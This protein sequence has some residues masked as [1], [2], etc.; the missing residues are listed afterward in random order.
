M[1]A[2]PCVLCHRVVTKYIVLLD[3]AKPKGHAVCNSCW[4]AAKQGRADAER[5]E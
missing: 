3:P 4:D 2:R 1:K 5:V